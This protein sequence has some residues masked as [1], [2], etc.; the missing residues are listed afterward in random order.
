MHSQDCLCQDKTSPNELNEFKSIIKNLDPLNVTIIVNV[1]TEEF[2]E[3]IPTH[4]IS[5]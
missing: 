3:Q 4:R 2:Q 1:T 5:T